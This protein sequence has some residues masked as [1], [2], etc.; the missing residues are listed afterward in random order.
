S[1]QSI[2][3]PVSLISAPNQPPSRSNPSPPRSTR[4]PEHHPGPHG[5]A[6]RARAHAPLLCSTWIGR[7]PIPSFPDAPPFL[8]LRQ[9]PPPLVNVAGEPSR[10]PAS[11]PFSPFLG[12]PIPLTSLAL[13]FSRAGNS[14]PHRRSSSALPH[15]RPAPA[16]S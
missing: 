2:P 16:R 4:L 13:S 10:S 6:A 11:H 5:R 14:T 12:S 9:T 8:R 3:P 7:S 1:I 15:R